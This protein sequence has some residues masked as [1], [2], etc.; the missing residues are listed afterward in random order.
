VEER[1]LQ[2]RF[3]EAYALWAERTWALIPMIW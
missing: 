2:A 1:A 3:G